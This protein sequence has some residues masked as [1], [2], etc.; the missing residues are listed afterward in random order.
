[1]RG[2]KIQR[3]SGFEAKPLPEYKPPKK[4]KACK[5]RK[6]APIVEPSAN[7]V[8]REFIASG[9]G[10]SS[11]TSLRDKSYAV[12]MPN[13]LKARGPG[14]RHLYDRD[15]ALVAIEQIK[16]VRSGFAPAAKDVD[17]AMHKY[18]N[19]ARKQR[20]KRELAK[21]WTD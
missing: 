17:A 1:M 19:Y 12:F 3:I 18:A 2:G 15:E 4:L 10:F 13:P 9:A 11:V 8:D 14:G 7:Q 21:E 6:L 5:K 20:N 16:A